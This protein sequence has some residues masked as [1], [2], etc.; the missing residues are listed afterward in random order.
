[1]EMKQLDVYTICA[2]YLGKALS[3]LID[4]LNPEIIILGSIYER[5]KSLLEP[6]MMDV[7]HREAFSLSK[8][9]CQIV[10]AGLSEGIGDIGALSLALISTEI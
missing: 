2:K 1:M 6:V 5:A 7:I 10:S 4:I 8:E 9:S 3:L